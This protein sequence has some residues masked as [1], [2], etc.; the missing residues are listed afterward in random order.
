MKSVSMRNRREEGENTEEKASLLLRCVRLEQGRTDV[1][2]DNRRNATH[3]A[4]CAEHQS[5]EMRVCTDRVG[6]RGS[7][8]A[9]GRKELLDQLYRRDASREKEAT[10]EQI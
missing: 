1:G 7:P 8:G 4:K 3:D 2:A 9:V 5:G 6:G 10:D